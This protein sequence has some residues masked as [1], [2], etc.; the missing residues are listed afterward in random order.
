MQGANKLLLA[1]YLIHMHDNTLKVNL[2]IL[3]P[4]T[5]LND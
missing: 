1:R 2:V 4:V 3:Q 5:L